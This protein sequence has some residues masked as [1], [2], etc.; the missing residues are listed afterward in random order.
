[1]LPKEEIYRLPR[2]VVERMHKE[3]ER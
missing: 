2:D 3:R 1:V